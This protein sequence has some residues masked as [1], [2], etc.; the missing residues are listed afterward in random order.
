MPVK[1]KAQMRAMRAAAHGDSRMGIP[2]DV[3]EDYLDKSEG[4]EMD[5][6]PEHVPAVGKMAGMEMERRKM[7]GCK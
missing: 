7:R 2:Q 1:S 3:A 5:E 4:M 6:M